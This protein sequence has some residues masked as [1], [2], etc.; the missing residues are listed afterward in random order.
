MLFL[1]LHGVLL[2]GLVVSLWDGLPSLERRCPRRFARTVMI[3]GVP[4]ALLVVANLPV[5]PVPLGVT[6]VA[7]ASLAYLEPDGRLLVG[8][9][10]A[11]GL[12]GWMTEL[13]H[14][15]GDWPRLL[16]DGGWILVIGASAWR[17]RRQRRLLM[18]GTVATVLAVS[19]LVNPD[20]IRDAVVTLTAGVLLLGYAANQLQRETA[21]AVQTERANADALTGALSRYG[22]AAWRLQVPG[23]DGAVAVLDLDDFK[24]INDTYGHAA[25]DA[26]L[27]EFA[28]RLKEACRREDAVVR[29]GGD[30]FSVWMP[31]GTQDDWASAVDRLHRVVSAEPY[32]TPGRLVQMGVSIGWATGALTEETWERADQALLDAKR[33]GKNQVKGESPVEVDIR[34]SPSRDPDGELGWLSDAAT[35]L[36]HPWSE[37][38]MLTNRSGTILAV[39]PAFEALTGL[40]RDQW[41]GYNPRRHQGGHTPSS[42]Y[43]ELWNTI[44]AGQVWHGA[45]ENRRPDGTRWWAE[46]T[47]VPI[48]VGQE[49]VGYWA[50]VR[51]TRPEPST[52]QA[53][54]VDG[55]ELD[56]VFQPIYRCPGR[57][58]WG[59]EALVRPRRGDQAISPAQFFSDAFHMGDGIRADLKAL[60][61]IARTVEQWSWP[62]GISLFCN[63]H[64]Q[65]LGD[66]GFSAVEDRLVSSVG[67]DQIVWELSE[68]RLEG[69]EVFTADFWRQSLPGRRWALDDV[70]SGAHD[71]WRLW[72]WPT[73]VVKVDLTW[74]QAL[75]TYPRARDM[76]GMLI[77]WVHQRGGQVIAEGIETETHWE[78]VVQMGFDGAQGYWLGRPQPSLP[79]K[80]GS[81]P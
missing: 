41:I 33:A 16:W 29:D 11:L 64:P 1:I 61:A 25:G 27:R 19:I 76:A 63:I 12:G 67:R 68:R 77:E 22:L 53:S 51:D 47:I 10:V 38:A 34:H 31:G 80:E 81:R 4:V 37:A 6:L 56:V 39:N 23:S 55:T 20:G 73:D 32:P 5:I 30:E 9:L 72:G 69:D 14:H 45:M 78:S 8:R 40:A 60:A 59:Y 52:W 26:I 24:W 3:L 43:Q 49:V 13:G 74:I 50:Q 65:T 15:A 18:V 36:W 17:F 70:G 79:M 48:R 35:V 42:V 28:R 46:E 62:P 71:L 54:V 75:L 2:A 21:L 57:D 7:M 66:P 44:S 58:L